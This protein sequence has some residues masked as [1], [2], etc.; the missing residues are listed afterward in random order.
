MTKSNN[1]PEASGVHRRPGLILTTFRFYVTHFGL[2]WRVM[3]PVIICFGL[4][5]LAGLFSPYLPPRT[6]VAWIFDT[7]RGIDTKESPTSIG[8]K[9]GA[10]FGGS[11]YNYPFILLAMCPLAIT[12]VQLWRGENVTARGM[13]HQAKRKISSALGAYFFLVAPGFVAGGVALTLLTSNKAYLGFPPSGDV[14]VI[15]FTVVA[16]IVYWTVHW[17][18]YN[19]CLIVEDLRVIPALRRSYE[20]VG[21]AWGRFTVVYLGLLAAGMVFTAVLFGLTLSMFS[22]AVP[23]FAPLQEILLSSKFYTLFVGGYVRLTLEHAPSLWIVA[24]MLVIKLFISAF[25]APIWAIVTT[26]FY[27]EKSK[28]LKGKNNS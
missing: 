25:L 5:E 4:S 11:A 2:L 14:T 12:I 21:E 22:I 10:G 1:M 13:W 26:H 27:L 19:Q 9:S 24:V 6:E 20:L 7:I 18:L 3:I 23:E 17:S 16:V 8:V 28:L 15:L